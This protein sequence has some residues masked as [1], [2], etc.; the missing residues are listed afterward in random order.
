MSLNCLPSSKSTDVGTSEVNVQWAVKSFT[1][2]KAVIGRRA[3]FLT[4]LV[5]RSIITRKKL[6][7]RHVGVKF[8]SYFMDIS[9]S[10]SD[11]GR[12]CR[13]VA[14]AWRRI[15]YFSQIAHAQTV[16]CNGW[17]DSAICNVFEFFNAF[18]ALL[19]D[20]QFLDCA[21]CKVFMIRGILGSWSSIGLAEPALRLY[22]RF[23]VEIEPQIR[24]MQVLFLQK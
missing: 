15:I 8:S 7:S 4:T 16:W 17:R 11:G 21:N 23:L 5:N 22:F 18:Y 10:S 13:I 9:S 1:I 6:F 12:S 3:H 24:S 19:D 14:L 20:V 2:W